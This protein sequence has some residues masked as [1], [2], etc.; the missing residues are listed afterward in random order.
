LFEYSLLC[1]FVE[2]PPYISFIHFLMIFS[3]KKV[4]MV[5]LIS[6]LLVLAL[7]FSACQKEV[8]DESFTGNNGNGGNPVTGDFRA[9][10]NGNQWVAN[11]AAGAVRNNGLI[12]ISGL[13]VDGLLLTITLTDSGVHTYTLDDQSFNAAAHVDSTLASTIS[14]TSN[15]SDD[16]TL[17]GGTVTITS[18]DTSTKRMSGT[19]RFK[20]FRPIDSLVR[21][22]TEG[23]FTNINYRTDAGINPG[24]PTDSF[25]VKLDGADWVNYSVI[26]LPVSLPPFINNIT[27]TSNFDANG[28]KNI[29]LSFN[30]SI[31]P[32]SYVF[33]LINITGV[34]NPT[35]S[36]TNP[37]PLSADGGNLTI[38][39]H[40]T[41]TRRI[42][43]TFNFVASPL[44]GPP[45]APINFT[46][47]YFSVV[48]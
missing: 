26:G 5:K 44:T 18:I 36:I 27:I 28:S 3:Q 48:Y 37:T 23:S 4:I 47:G 16:S 21:N 33:D 19:F 32:G 6:G 12:N 41:T 34:Y 38:L 43:G 11:A 20:V 2:L 22:F 8:S 39:E 24:N 9:K 46:E 25:R 1:S 35:N 17:A 13:N 31:T 40:N 30:R 7:L 10:I 42:R 15:A 14:F 45:P 29:G